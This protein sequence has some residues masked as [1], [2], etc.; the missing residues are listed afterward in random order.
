M[1]RDTDSTSVTL[2]TCATGIRYHWNTILSTHVDNMDHFF[3]ASRIDNSAM[4]LCRMMVVVRST[5]LCQDL[6]VGGDLLGVHWQE[7]AKVDQSS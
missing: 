2:E 3:S 1:P 7:L 5:M 4:R 6:H